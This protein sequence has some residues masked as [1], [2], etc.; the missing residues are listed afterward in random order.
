MNSVTVIIPTYNRW[1][2]VCAAVDSVLTQTHADTHCL[3]VDDG[4]KDNTAAHLREKYG[5]RIEIIA[6]ADNRGQSFRRNQGAM[7]AT[8]DYIC[9]LDSDDVFDPA[10]V[11][12]RMALVAANPD[13]VKICFGLFRKA[14]RDKHS[15][16]TMKQRGELLSL[17]DYLQ[18]MSWLCNNS[19][20]AHRETFLADGLY[21]PNLRNRED[22]ELIIRLLSKHSF[23]YCGAE[24]GQI[25]DLCS[26]RARDNFANILDPANSF[27]HFIQ[28]NPVVR[29]ALKPETLQHLIASEV[30]EQLRA[31]YRLNRFAEYRMLFR[32]AKQQHQMIH[33][34]KFAKR[35]WISFLKD[36]FTDNPLVTEVRKDILA[37]GN[38]QHFQT[39]SDKGVADIAVTTR[40][41]PGDS[42]C[43]QLDRLIDQGR[44]FKA[45]TTSTVAGTSELGSR[46]VIKRYNNKGFISTLK[47]LIRASRAE[48]AFEKGLILRK[49]GVNTPRPL[50]YAVRY[51][52]GLPY[53][54]Y[55]VCEQSPGDTLANLYNR[56]ELTRQQWPA[57]VASIHD[58]L[59]SLHSRAI[60]HGDIKATNL[61]MHDGEVALIDLDSL[62]IHWS[63]GIFERFRRKDLHALERKVAGYIEQGENRE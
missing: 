54:C 60:T 33:P 17:D 27:A 56:G 24:I 59:D 52:N 32:Q 2:T 51:K 6:N 57:I 29:S 35:Y 25:R 5:E 38:Y 42:L 16:L 20:L 34:G 3:V 9:F 28:S 40:I 61:L 53:N 19:F 21:N 14:G 44:S 39:P 22:I 48:R 47:M 11:A 46:W 15:L 1:P 23:Y 13:Q 36:L 26:N 58:I 41:S 31:L 63:R 43:D 49:L 12:S 8:S 62:R 10:S 37:S 18:N 50:L 55:I 4:S 7:A 30:E 45:D